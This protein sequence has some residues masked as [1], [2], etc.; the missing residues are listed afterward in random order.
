MDVLL[1]T[2][3]MFWVMR[4]PGSD[5]RRTKWRS[6]SLIALGPISRNSPGSLATFAAI[7]RALSSE[8]RDCGKRPAQRNGLRVTAPALCSRLWGSDRLATRQDVI[9]VT[10]QK[11]APSRWRI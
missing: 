11:V 6:H 8:I 3:P 5:H 7:R 10:D 9:G 1:I 4:G 2:D